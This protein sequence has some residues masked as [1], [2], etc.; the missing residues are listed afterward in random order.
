VLRN[1]DWTRQQLT[2]DDRKWMRGLP[3]VRF[4]DGFSMGAS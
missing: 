1:D 3:V 2:E 4:L